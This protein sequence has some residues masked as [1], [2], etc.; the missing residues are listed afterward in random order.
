[1]VME[2]TNEASTVGREVEPSKWGGADP[3]VPLQ[4]EGGA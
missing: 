3:D 2:L 1:M 4:P